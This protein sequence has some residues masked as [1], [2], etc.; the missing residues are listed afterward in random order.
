MVEAI[1]TILEAQR[2]ELKRNGILYLCE[3]LDKDGVPSK[4]NNI[5]YDEYEKKF[6]S[7]I[8]KIDK[9]LKTV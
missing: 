9:I 3:N 6:G 7:V 1:E 2:E 8:R 5:I 4:Y